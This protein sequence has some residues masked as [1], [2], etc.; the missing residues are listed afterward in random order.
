[1]RNA[2]KGCTNLAS[3][4]LP[5]SVTF[6]GN[7]AFG[8]CVNLKAIYNY[9][10][11][12]IGLGE[13]ISPES[14][15]VFEG[16]DKDLCILYVPKNS[17]EKYQAAEGWKEFKQIMPLPTASDIISGDAN[18]DSEV[19][20]AD[21][22]EIVNFI[23][24]KPSAKFLETAADLNGDG[25]INVSDIVK[26]VSIIMSTNNVRQRSPMVGSIDHDELMLAE[27]EDNALSLCLNNENCYV[28]SQFDVRLSDGLSLNSIMLNNERR[29]G[30]LMTYS[31]IGEN[32]YR[33]VIYSPENRPFTGN[34]GELLKIKTEGTGDVEISNILFIT[35]NQLEKTF[36]TLHYGATMIQ[37]LETSESKDVYSLDGRQIR[38][39][40]KT[41]DGLKK[42]VYI[43]NGKKMIQ[44]K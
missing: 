38:K 6:I 35:S 41:T 13:N 33:V 36:S 30:H 37:T 25:E 23:L 18:G 17:V 44:N 4:T 10:T 9:A 12:P 11:E 43:I 14:S 39:Q 27:S 31:A 29:N 15:H 40:V 32:L 42:G 26:L 20:V 5:K 34:S 21:I 19:N 16:I 24:G 2:F 1:M 28:A 3:V 22:V 8:G 7:N